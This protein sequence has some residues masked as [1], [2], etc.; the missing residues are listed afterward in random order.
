M[1]YEIIKLIKIS[2]PLKQFVFFFSFEFDAS[3][4]ARSPYG[5]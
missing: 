5:K 1:T 4:I 3:L 2:Y